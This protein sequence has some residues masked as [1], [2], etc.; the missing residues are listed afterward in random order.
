MTTQH[1]IPEYLDWCPLCHADGYFK[2]TDEKQGL[3]QVCCSKCDHTGPVSEVNAAARMWNSR[4]VSGL[5]HT[6]ASENVAFERDVARRTGKEVFRHR[7]GKDREKA[8]RGD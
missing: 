8:Y 1:E 5:D 6:A 2:R 4:I 3:W 7:V